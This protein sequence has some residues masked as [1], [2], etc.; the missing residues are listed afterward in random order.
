MSTPSSQSLLRPPSPLYT[1]STLS[2]QVLPTPRANFDALFAESPPDQFQMSPHGVD[3]EL[4]IA[5]L[6]HGYASKAGPSSSTQQRRSETPASKKRKVMEQF[7]NIQREILE[8]FRKEKSEKDVADRQFL[9]SLRPSLKERT[10]KD[11][12]DRQFFLSLWSS[13]NKGQR[14]MMLIDSSF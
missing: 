6:E 12:A 14:R 10:E 1:Q 5:A 4:E 9:L 3:K 11:D 2:S 8:E 13:L 7:M